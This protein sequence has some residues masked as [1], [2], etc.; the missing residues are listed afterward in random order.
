MQEQKVSEH[1]TISRFKSEGANDCIQALLNQLILKLA[2]LKE[3]RFKNIFID[4]RK[5]EANA[6]I[7]S[8]VWKN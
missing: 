6:N 3:I 4:G 7:Y 8:F 1:N 2:E 5:I